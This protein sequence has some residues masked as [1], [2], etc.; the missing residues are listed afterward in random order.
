MTKT[1]LQS[2]LS[3][4]RW[5]EL[6]VV[7]ATVLIYGLVTYQRNTVWKDDISLWSDCIK[8]SPAKARPHNNLGVAYTEKGLI[9]KAIVEIKESLRL[10]PDF[11]NAFISLGN[12]YMKIGL[13]DKAIY[14]Y[15]EALRL[16]PDYGEAYVNLGNAIISKGNI[17]QAITCYKTSIALTPGYVPARVNLASAY[18]SKGMTEEAIS[19]YKKALEL[20][21]DNPD[22]H[23]NLG[24][25]Y[26]QLAKSQEPRA[27]SYEHFLN[28][29]I[30]EY[31]KTLMLNPYDLQAR[32]RIMKLRAKGY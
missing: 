25:A 32:E 17:E 20:K 6:L 13:T 15:N 27:M 12:A 11:I 31:K 2:I 23:Y 18:G 21:S 8:K 1:A 4:S 28:T 14:Q 30:N 7:I 22:I 3:T 10:K 29:A 9:E 5:V 24:V 26:E 19:E 16:K